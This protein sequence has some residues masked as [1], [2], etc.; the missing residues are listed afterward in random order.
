VY[1]LTVDRDMCWSGDPQTDLVTAETYYR[2]D[3]IARNAQRFI[4]TAAE[5]E[6]VS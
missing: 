3:D 2:D 1:F 6:H 5:N 4:G